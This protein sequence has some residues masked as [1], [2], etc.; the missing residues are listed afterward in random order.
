[1]LSNIDFEAYAPCIFIRHAAYKAAVREIRR[2]GND[3][4]RPAGRPYVVHSESWSGTT[5]AIIHTNNDL[6]LFF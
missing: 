6:R 1:M 2:L 5:Y 4:G 3:S